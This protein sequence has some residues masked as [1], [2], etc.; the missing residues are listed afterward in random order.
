MKPTLIIVDD[1]QSTREELRAALEDRF[2]VLAT[3]GSAAAG[4]ETYRRLQPSLVLMDV[5]MPGR[6]GI[7]AVREIMAGPAPHPKIVMLSGVTEEKYILEAY[8]AGASDY[9]FKPPDY[10][11]IGDVLASLA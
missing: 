8:Q 7:E 1:I 4:V 11:R 10:K 3:A 6:S 9:L 5:V 2:E